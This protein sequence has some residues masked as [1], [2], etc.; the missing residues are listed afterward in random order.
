MLV[1]TTSW[2]LSDLENGAQVFADAGGQLSALAAAVQPANPAMY[3]SFV[4]NA[5][6]LTEPATSLAN[7]HLLIALS[8]SVT[9]IGVRLRTTEAAYRAVEETNEALAREITSALEESVR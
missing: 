2:D 4:A 6:A 9:D 8:G 5:A 3:G 1:T 7:T